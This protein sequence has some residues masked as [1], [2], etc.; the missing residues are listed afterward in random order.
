MKIN[1]LKSFANS[2]MVESVCKQYRK[3]NSKF[4]TGLSVAS[5]VAK[6]AY[7]C[8]VY[9]W[10]NE[11]NKNIPKD[12]K[13]FISGLDIANG[14]LMILAQ[15]G[16][17]L[18]ISK[19][20]TQLKIFEKVLGKYFTP[21]RYSKIEQ[22]ICKKLKTN[23]KKLIKKEFENYKNNIETAFTHFSTLL[24]TTIFAKRVLVPF[25]ATP[26]ADK[27]KAKMEVSNY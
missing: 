16:A 1:P 12:K 26:L 6:D 21:E 10:Q 2:K 3:N 25:V 13:K 19:R 20:A 23:D 27:I 5:I 4:I 22:N 9:V 17:Y 15:I 8:Y 18:T 7:G 11:H 14:V 24:T